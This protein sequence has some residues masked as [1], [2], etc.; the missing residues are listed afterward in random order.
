MNTTEEGKNEK[1]FTGFGKKVDQFLDEL[2]E[3]GEK[4]QKEFEEKFEELKETGEKL[5]KEAENKER[6]K[7]VESNLK[8]A[9]DELSS[10]FKAAFKKRQP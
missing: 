6:W 5:K 1:T 4:L 9:A 8:K 2:H 10:A 3:A 7:E